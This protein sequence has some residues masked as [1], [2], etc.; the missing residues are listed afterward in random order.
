MSYEIEYTDDF[1]RSLKKLTKK[2][3][4]ISHDVELLINSLRTEP[5]LGTNI[6]SGFRKIRFAISSKGKGK[7]GGGRLITFVYYHKKT[8]FLMEIYDRAEIV[9]VSIRELKRIRDTLTME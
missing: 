5:D 2:Y 8:V 7:S 4:S 6:G 9:N 3:I 1:L